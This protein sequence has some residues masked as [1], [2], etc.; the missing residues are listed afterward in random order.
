MSRRPEPD[1]HARHNSFDAQNVNAKSS[2]VRSQPAVEPY[3][4]CRLSWFEIALLICATVLAVALH[5]SPILNS[6]LA[7]PLTALFGAISYLS[8]VSGFFFAA[9]TQFL[10]FPA[11]R[12]F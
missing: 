1:D 2:R 5:L 6:S 12:P 10:P 9:T 3:W 4:D 11:G 7:I 8:P